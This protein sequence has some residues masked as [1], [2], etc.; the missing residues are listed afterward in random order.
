[1]YHVGAVIAAAQNSYK[2]KLA[3]VMCESYRLLG[4]ANGEVVII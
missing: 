3:S 1:M 4:L 2:Q